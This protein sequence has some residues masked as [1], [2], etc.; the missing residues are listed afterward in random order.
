[1]RL[2]LTYLSK[3]FLLRLSVSVLYIY[4]PAPSLIY[5]EMPCEIAVGQRCGF[6]NV[7]TLY[8]VRIINI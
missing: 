6:V 2:A 1:M 3:Q 7:F 4:I 8:T 5:E